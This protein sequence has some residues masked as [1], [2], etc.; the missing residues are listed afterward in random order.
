MRELL[1]KRAAL[2]TEMSAL[3]AK[4]LNI[5]ADEERRFGDIEAEIA[6]VDAAI[7]RLERTQGFNSEP[8]VDADV[9]QEKRNKEGKPFASFGEQLQAI[10]RAQSPGSPQVDRRLF[11]VKAAASGMSEAVPADGGFLVQHDF[12]TDLLKKTYETG[13]L[14]SRCSRRQVGPNANGI[15]I[16]VEDESSRATG[17]RHGGVRVYRDNEADLILGSKPKLRQINMA[18]ERMTGAYYATEELLQDATALTSFVFPAFTE[19]FGFK[20]DDEIVNGTGAGQML[21]ILNSACRVTVAKEA[22]QPA[23]TL[24][25]K[26]I[27]KMW[28]RMWAKS[29]PNAIWLI[30]QDIE[31]Q[32]G[33]MAM[34]VGVGGVPVFL[35]ASGASTMPYSTLFGR[36]II[37][38][39]QCATLGTEGDIILAD[40]SQYLYIDKG[41]IQAAESIHV[42]FLYAEST[43][44]FILRNNGQPIWNTPLTP[45]KGT[46]NT[47]SPFVTLATRA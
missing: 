8:P 42:R 9:S 21:G 17:S 39:E 6:K 26:N 45:Y 5:S 37:P 12:Q 29:R 34:P 3:A 28:M 13:V 14:V 23:A 30:N 19:E 7:K 16:N 10:A 24:D 38:I 43:F 33:S 35:P 25:Y 31:E 40:M 18:L 46:G 4:G 32:L 1:Q 27:Q 41:G 20:T 2:E 15:K 22:G 36:P 47:L 11:A 44:R